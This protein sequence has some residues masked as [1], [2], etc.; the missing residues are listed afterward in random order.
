MARAA[1]TSS[2][3]RAGAPN[4][5]STGSPGSEAGSLASSKS[6]GG[7]LVLARCRRCPTRATV[8]LLMTTGGGRHDAGRGS[9]LAGVGGTSSRRATVQ[10]CRQLADV[11]D[12]LSRVRAGGT[13]VD[14]RRHRSHPAC[15]SS[16]RPRPGCGLRAGVCGRAAGRHSGAGDRTADHGCAELCGAR[17]RSC[18]CPCWLATTRHE[19]KDATRSLR[20]SLPELAT[21]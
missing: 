3:R 2:E 9:S 10:N 12:A 21:E 15:R 14:H 16:T 18:R 13:S 5:T 6:A 1:A 8:R 4:V 17:H 7:R 20:R 19:G 11:A